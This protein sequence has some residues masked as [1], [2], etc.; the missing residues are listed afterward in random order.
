MG[1]FSR[2]IQS[3][4]LKAKLGI[5]VPTLSALL[6]LVVVISASQGPVGLPFGAVLGIL[7]ADL[8]IDAGAEYT[9]RAEIVVNP[10]RLPRI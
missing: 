9:Q 4:S 7:L 6:L 10:I 8:G 2:N 5:A 3:L 1:R